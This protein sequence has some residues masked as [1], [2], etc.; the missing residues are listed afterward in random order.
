[1]LHRREV[2]RHALSATSTHDT[3]RGEDAR[4]LLYTLSE[5]PD[6]W[7]EAVARWRQALRPF[8]TGTAK[9]PVPDAR[10]EWLIFQALAGMLPVNFDPEDQASLTDLKA[11]FSAYIEK[12]LREA[13]LHSN[14]SAP[15]LGYEQ[16]V[17]DYAESMLNGRADGFLR[18]FRNVLAP[19]AAAG[20]RNS[21]CQ[22]V[23]K[24][25]C[26]GIP[27]IYNGAELFDFSLVDPDNRRPIDIAA[28][29]RMPIPKILHGGGAALRDGSLKLGL[30]AAMLGERKRLPALFAEGDYIP[31]SVS[32]VRSQHLL[33][34]ARRHE[35]HAM[36]VIVTRLPYQ[37]CE[38]AEDA[39]TFWA[40]TAVHLP[41]NHASHA[42][43]SLS[44]G[45][46]LPSGGPLRIGP[47][48]HDLPFAVV[49]S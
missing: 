10:T 5:A 36:I 11:R 16:A 6:V 40:N 42:Y 46:E 45:A 32:G 12:A 29:S 25:T 28:L 2:A 7:I 27:D 47:L 31:L 3:K 35:G 18:D 19:F 4:A 44:D 1:M 22:T 15:D 34:F 41:E 37:A 24:L 49:I 30:I 9:G 8:T 39:E 38:A 20:L 26:P 14:W 23:L 43:R 48:L 13:K 33:A 21:L 17:K